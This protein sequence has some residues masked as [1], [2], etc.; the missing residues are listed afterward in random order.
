MG[1]LNSSKKFAHV[2]SN[3]H[4]SG[5]CNRSCYFCIGQHMM[6]LDALNNLNTWP[7]EGLDEFVETCLERGVTEIYLTGSNTDP[8]LYRHLPELTAYLRERV[9]GAILGL[10]TNGAARPD[11]L[12]L[13]DKASVTVCSANPTLNRLVMGGDP[14]DLARITAHIAPE[15][16]ILYAVLTPG[17]LQQTDAVVDLARAHGIPKV[18]LREPYGQPHVG[19]PYWLPA[20]PDGYLFDISPYWDVEGVRVTYWDVHY[21]HVESVNLYANGRVSTDY[22]ITRGHSEKGEVHPQTEFPGGR[23]RAQWVTNP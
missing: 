8:L 13:F 20:T 23:V 7:L 6:A 15:A 12:R 16:V 18:N 5:P 10:R 17:T 21:V 14:P 1:C 19:L 3:I 22:P 11:P 9:P 4:F 2:F